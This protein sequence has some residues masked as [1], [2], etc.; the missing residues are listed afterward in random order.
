MFLNF[1]G[2][3]NFNNKI[4]FSRLLKMENTEIKENENNNKNI[5]KEFYIFKL[6]DFKNILNTLNFDITN[7]FYA[8]ETYLKNKNLYLIENIGFTKIKSNEISKYKYNCCSYP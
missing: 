6:I 8:L 3:H 7:N 1:L 5:E 2:T 4:E